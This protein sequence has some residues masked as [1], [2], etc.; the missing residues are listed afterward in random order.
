MAHV[1][2]ERPLFPGRW[3]QI[4][5]AGIHRAGEERTG[6]ISPVAEEA[7]EGR[8][9]AVRRAEGEEEAAVAAEDL[10][11]PVL[12][13][14]GGDSQVPRLRRKAEQDAPQGVV[15]QVSQLQLLLLLLLLLL[16][17]VNNIDR[18]TL[19]SAMVIRG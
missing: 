15:G 10:P 5:H 9:S 18:T 13:D 19:I 1:V 11:A 16:L 12:G 17:A 6:Q 8:H 2:D 4:H 3:G 14:G 7:K